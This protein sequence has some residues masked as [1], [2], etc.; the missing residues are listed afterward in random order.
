[1][2]RASYRS[3]VRSVVLSLVAVLASL[4]IAPRLEAQSAQPWSIQGSALFANQEVNGSAISGVGY[5]AQLRYT[6]SA[7]SLGVGY[8]SSTHDHAP[9]SLTLS[10]AFLEPRYAVDIG[11]DRFAPYVAGR[12]AFL[13]EQS[14]LKVGATVAD[15]SSGG[16]AFGAGAGLL[17]RM[18]SSVN[19]DFGAA[20]VSQSFA[21]AKNTLGTAHFKSFLGYVAKVGVS[22]GF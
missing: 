17:A 13:N 19:V 5:E 22:I 4:V 15:F 21:D 6:F 9:E 7:W 11:S 16:T 12:V 1:M 20:L 18:S 10:G 2:F 8:Q 3:Q 14:R